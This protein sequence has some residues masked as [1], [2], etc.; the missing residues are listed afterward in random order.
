VDGGTDPGLSGEM[1]LNRIE[2]QAERRMLM[3]AGLI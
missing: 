1:L 3:I 2:K